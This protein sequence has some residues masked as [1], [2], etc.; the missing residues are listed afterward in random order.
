ML[1]AVKNMILPSVTRREESY[2][3]AAPFTIFLNYR[4]EAQHIGMPTYMLMKRAF[5]FLL[6][7]AIFS[8]Y[9]NYRGEAQ[10][11]G[12]NLKRPLSHSISTTG[13]LQY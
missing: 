4:S 10:H 7:A 3:C 1:Y 11:I 12:I 9:L 8:I 5:C 2:I 6:T 13:V